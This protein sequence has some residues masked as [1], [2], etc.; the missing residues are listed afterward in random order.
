MLLLLLKTVE[1]D[2]DVELL[3]SIIITLGSMYP[4]MAPQSELRST[5]HVYMATPQGSN[6]PEKF[7]PPPN[8]AL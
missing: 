7:Y 1:V 6:L 3:L 8:Q 4:Q 2:D 5:D